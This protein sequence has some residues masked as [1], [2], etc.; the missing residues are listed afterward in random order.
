MWSKI[1]VQ[2]KVIFL[3][4]L[5]YKT[6]WKPCFP[7]D[8]RPLVEGY[9]ANFG[10]SL[11]IFEFFRFGLFF[12]FLIFFCFFFCVFLVH[13]TVASVLLSA[14]VKRFDVSR[15]RDFFWYFMVTE[16]GF[17]F[18]YSSVAGIDPAAFPPRGGR[19]HSSNTLPPYLLCCTITYQSHPCCSLLAITRRK[20]S[21]I[22]I[23]AANALKLITT[24][25][26]VQRN[27]QPTNR[28]VIV[29]VVAEGP[30]SLLEQ[31]ERPLNKINENLVS[32]TTSTTKS[33]QVCMTENCSH[34]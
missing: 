26:P 12:P 23:L 15:M 4:I 29:V 1:A 8:Q 22:S 9:I 30:T 5:P 14:L 34:N 10:I 27:I 19:K 18:I 31:L 32:C 21:T 20:N 17:E 28:H 13:P 33:M 11:D 2:K 3:L 6:W 7:M 24:R 16:R 25:I